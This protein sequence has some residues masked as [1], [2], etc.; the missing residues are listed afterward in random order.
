MQV[1]STLDPLT[2]VL[3]HVVV[4]EIVQPVMLSAGVELWGVCTA[5]SGA[6]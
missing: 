5:V 6:L 1:L 3:M 2:G 4:D